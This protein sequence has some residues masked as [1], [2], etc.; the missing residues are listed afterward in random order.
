MITVIARAMDVWLYHH[1]ASR[2]VFSG[3]LSDLGLGLGG[4]Y[5]ENVV[6]DS[7][8]YCFTFNCLPCY[9]C[10]SLVCVSGAITVENDG[11]GWFGSYSFY[12][13]CSFGM[14]DS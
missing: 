6:L 14:F 10:F 2:A 5:S 8:G 13:L 7:S 11:V 3:Y 1:S 4:L 12:P 9:A